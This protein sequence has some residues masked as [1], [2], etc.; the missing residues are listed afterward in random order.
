MMLDLRNINGIDW[1]KNAIRRLKTENPNLGD[2]EIKKMAYVQRGVRLD[3]VINSLVDLK[4]KNDDYID[5]K[6]SNNN[7]G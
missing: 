3:V 1:C 4:K 7:E 2:D 6:W 5:R